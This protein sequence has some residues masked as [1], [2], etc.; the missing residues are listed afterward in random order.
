MELYVRSELME[1]QAR[2]S[3][4]WNTS[5]PMLFVSKARIMLRHKGNRCIGSSAVAINGCSILDEVMEESR[6]Q[7][8]TPSALQCT[9]DQALPLR[10]GGHAIRK[11]STRGR[12][13]ERVVIYKTE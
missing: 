2:R 11:H 4:H 9:I 1:V 10:L 8:D 3:P 13:G 5:A 7:A 6:R 12:N